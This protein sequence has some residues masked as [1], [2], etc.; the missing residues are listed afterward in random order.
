MIKRKLKKPI[1]D[2]KTRQ[3]MAEF[4]DTHDLADYWDELESIE[5]KV[6]RKLTSTLNIRFEP[7]ILEKLRIE[8][9]KKGIGP[10][11]LVRMWA[12]EKLQLR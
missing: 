12:L 7:K 1:P 5:V 9:K 8:A 6:S 2:F 3:E 4:W 11:T 10:T